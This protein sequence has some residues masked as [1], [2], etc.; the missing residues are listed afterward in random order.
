MLHQLTSDQ[1]MIRDTTARFLSD[2]APL[3]RLRKLRDDPAGYDPGY[4]TSGAELG[5]T[6]LL[7]DRKSVV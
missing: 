3:A 4:W 6:M 2:R 1:D 7:V 5:W